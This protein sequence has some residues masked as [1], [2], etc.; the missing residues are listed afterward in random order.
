MCTAMYVDLCPQNLLEAVGI[1]LLSLTIIQGVAMSTSWRIS[2]RSLVS[3]KN[4]S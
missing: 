2:Q 4:L 1:L 3:L